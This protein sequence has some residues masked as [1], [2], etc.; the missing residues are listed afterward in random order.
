MNRDDAL[1]LEI[2]RKLKAQRPALARSGIPANQIGDAAAFAT[3]TRLLGLG[4][5]GDV[6][7][8][9]ASLV[10][11]YP[12]HA[13]ALYLMGLVA[14]YQWESQ[15]KAA[16]FF[17]KAV[18]LRPNFAEGHYNLGYML[19]RL[20]DDIGAVRA[21]EA[22]LT[23]DPRF[24]GAWVNLGN[25]KLASGDVCA[26]LECYEQAKQGD[27]SNA[28]ARYNRAIAYLLTEDYTQGWADYEARLDTPLHRGKCRY[29]THLPLWDGTPQPGKRLLV[30]AEQGIGD[31]IMCLGYTRELHDRRF[32]WRDIIWA[33]QPEL[34][35]TFSWCSYAEP[36]PEVDLWIPTMSLMS[37]LGM[38][39]A[40]RKPYFGM[41]QSGFAK[42]VPGPRLP[43]VGYVYA[44]SPDY[45]NNRRRSTDPALWADLLATP[46]IE[47][48][49]L[50][51]GQG[52]QPKDWHE[53]Q[54]DICSLDL[55][56]SVDT[57]CAHLA[58]ALGVPVWILL[59]SWPDYRW[60]LESETT[61]WYDSAT[62]IR[63]AKDGDWAEVL[64]R[65]KA[66]LEA[67]RD[68]R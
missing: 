53:T 20:G 47:W 51:Y 29:P 23:L 38:P 57:A 48:V 3:A 42:L 66:K 31:T 36:W 33:I 45:E 52:Y 17:Q 59:P 35:P 34:T 19:Q 46:G 11:R 2:A 30:V 1:G 63:Q 28:L 25:A 22:T 15:E 5:F 4:Q 49:C 65:V 13:E 24:A 56:I 68:T 64:G 61:L 54:D 9:A 32:A 16:V 50:Q 44:G 39:P 26:A 55:V 40:P 43:R 67:W 41:R 62:L 58:G 14:F 60:G 18:D 21:Y 10:Q 12:N 7:E 6:A 27:A 8:I 37:R